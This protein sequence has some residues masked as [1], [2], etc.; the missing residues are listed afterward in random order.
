M[1]IYDKEVSNPNRSFGLDLLRALA[2]I[3]VVIYHIHSRIFP[4]DMSPFF[5]NLGVEIFFVLS[6]FLIGT[7]IIKI[8]NEEGKFQ[9]KKIKNFWIRRWFRTLPNYYL[10]LI[11]S[12]ILF[13]LFYYHYFI[14]K[15]LNILAFFVFLQSSITQHPGFFPVAWSLAIEEW[16]YLLFP[17]WLLIVSKL[18]LSKYKTVIFSVL[19]F[20]FIE[21]LFRTVIA[22]T[23]PNLNFDGIFNHMMPF[24][25]DGIAIGGLAAFFY[26]YHK[27][28]WENNKTK[29]FILGITLF[30][31]SS[32]YFYLDFILNGN[33]TLFTKIFFLDI[34]GISIALLFPVIHSIKRFRN[35]SI[36]RFITHISLIS[37]SLYLSHLYIIAGIN[38]LA[39]N[40][41]SKISIS[42]IIIFII[43]TV[44]YKFFEKPM[45]SIRERFSKSQNNSIEIK[46]SQSTI[47]PQDTSNV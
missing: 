29:I 46:N 41:F 13:S 16:F 34:S 39:I 15:N 44:Q 31:F 43:S 38:T 14:L 45:T 23:S 24:R 9:F 42:L 11:V 35:E 19:S 40:N 21:I 32:L 28:F 30:I 25:L 26:F 33:N 1:K 3:L 27:D 12:I 20:I 36:T 37:Y 6:G 2:I 18:N 47:T 17:L 8:F 5:G 4:T 22:I 10:V 7:I